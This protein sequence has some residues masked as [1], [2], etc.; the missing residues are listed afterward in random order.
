MSDKR[1]FEDRIKRIQANA[2][3]PPQYAPIHDESMHG[4]TTPKTGKRKRA[5]G[6][7]RLV[8][9][10]GAFAFLFTDLGDESMSNLMPKLAELAD[11]SQVTE[12][13]VLTKPVSIQTATVQDSNTSSEAAVARQRQSAT[14]INAASQ[15]AENLSP[16]LRKIAL[17]F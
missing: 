17:K 7:A 12:I 6:F 13:A 10:L 2:G 14:Q 5:S 15:A 11:I 9:T 3:K 8:L 16:E 1:G 4:V